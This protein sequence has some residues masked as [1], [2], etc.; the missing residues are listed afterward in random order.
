MH[1]ERSN[2]GR[3]FF[4]VVN[5][6][7]GKYKDVPVL[8]GLPLLLPCNDGMSLGA[9]CRH[10][11]KH[12]QAHVRWLKPE[13]AVLGDST[14]DST[15]ASDELAAEDGSGGNSL[16][17][18]PPKQVVLSC[19]MAAA[20]PQ[21]P[22]IKR[23]TGVAAVPSLGFTQTHDS[24]EPERAAPS[25]P[26]LDAAGPAA[27]SAVLGASASPSPRRREVRG[28]RA[29][30][31]LEFP[32]TP[33]EAVQSPRA[34]ARQGI[35]PRPAVRGRRASAPAVPTLS[36][37]RRE[38]ARRR[39]AVEAVKHSVIDA[40][41]LLCVGLALRVVGATDMR[42]PGMQ[43]HPSRSTRFV[44][45]AHDVLS[46]DWLESGMAYDDDL[47]LPEQ[48]SSGV[49]ARGGGVARCCV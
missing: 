43:L 30:H 24:V 44:A 42:Q 20:S 45:G 18:A 34:D 6:R 5:R 11:F 41:E 15:S 14:P 40:S 35:V 10:A 31:P 8:F 16:T 36:P 23:V 32:S 2:A 3:L 26:A 13:G 37:R 7:V 27:N 48:C 19:S 25:A 22:A 33:T 9:L 29:V 28:R 12:V 39:S 46:F 4:Q 1:V 21:V 47:A 49:S 17:G 38:H